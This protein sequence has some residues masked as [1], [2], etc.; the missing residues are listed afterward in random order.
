MGA[1]VPLSANTPR[2]G[3]FPVQPEVRSHHQ[4]PHRC[5]R[6]VVLSSLSYERVIILP[7]LGPQEQLPEVWADST[8]HSSMRPPQF[9]PWVASVERHICK[10]HTT[11]QQPLHVLGEAGFFY[12]DGWKTCWMEAGRESMVGVQ[13]YIFGPKLFVTFHLFWKQILAILSKIRSF[14]QINP[15]LLVYW[16]NGNDS[17]LITRGYVTFSISSV[18]C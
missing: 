18:W 12:S 8:Q 4:I 13:K 10:L 9:L 16:S 15:A 7:G 14:L 11:F 2:L 3:T 17:I 6:R 5:P 1:S